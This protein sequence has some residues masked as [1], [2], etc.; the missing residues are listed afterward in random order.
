MSDNINI[1]NWTHIG[2]VILVLVATLALIVTPGI[3]ILK[4]SNQDVKDCRIEIVYKFIPDSV[5]LDAEYYF[6]KTQMDSIMRQLEYHEAVL[7]NKFQTLLTQK[8]EE[9]WIK[10]LFVYVF[11]IVVAVLG[12]FGYRSFTDLEEKTIKTA[13]EKA[14]ETVE[15][16]VP[17]ITATKVTSEC[18]SKVP[19]EV[20]SYLD[21]NLA[22]KVNDKIEAYFLGDGRNVIETIVQRE[23]RSQRST[24][25]LTESEEDNPDE[26][27][28]SDRDDHEN[29]QNE[30]T[31]H[32]GSDARVEDANPTNGGNNIDAML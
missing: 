32:E 27:V 2:G 15:A 16:K 17:E 7:N 19:I 13:N 12:F 28:A 21:A 31:S 26:N 9:D 25:H 5:A 1:H 10:D 18:S 22:Q 11:G 4:K 29:I 8:S 24:H 14:K 3:A 6:S 23:V 20:N 30:V